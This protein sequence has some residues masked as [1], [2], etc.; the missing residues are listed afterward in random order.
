MKIIVCSKIFNFWEPAQGDGD[1]IV[2]IYRNY[3]I[4]KVGEQLSE[5]V[6]KIGS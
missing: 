2:I 3:I 6:I 5:N 4:Q 1:Y